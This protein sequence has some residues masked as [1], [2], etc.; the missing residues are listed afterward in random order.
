MS[1]LPL[2]APGQRFEQPEAVRKI[3]CLVPGDTANSGILYVQSESIP[4][5]VAFQRRL[6]ANDFRYEVKTVTSQTIANLYKAN[7][8]NEASS[9]QLTAKELFKY[10][11]DRKG[12]D[13]LI[14]TDK[15]KGTAFYMRILGDLY[16]MKDMTMNFEDGKQLQNSIYQSMSKEHSTTSY[17]DFSFMG[18]R[19]TDRN[20]LPE[21]LDSIRVGTGP[22]INDGQ[23]M[24]L[25]LQEKQVQGVT[26]A[27]LG[28]PELQ[29]KSLAF[30][31]SI[32][33]GIVVVTGPTGAGKT[34]TLKVL[35]DMIIE[36][37][38]GKKHV[39]TIEDPAEYPIEGA[40]QL[41]VVQGKTGDEDMFN[42]AVKGSLRLDPDTIL[43]GEVRD[44]ETANLAFR[45]AMTGHQVFTSLH[46]I[47]ALGA[48]SRLMDL[49]VPDYLVTDP[50]ILRGITA[51]RLVKTLCPHCKVKF[52]DQEKN[53]EGEKKRRLFSVIGAEDIDN[54]FVANP[55]GCDKCINGFNGRTLVVEVLVTDQ[56]LMSHVKNKDMMLAL[57]YLRGKKGYQTMIDVAIAKIKSGELDPFEVEHHVGPLDL[58]IL[59][60]DHHIDSDEL[61][62]H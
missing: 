40:N 51:Q 18:S 15:E 5:V 42:E 25:R 49:G 58:Q 1:N 29:R 44:S 11:A 41:K 4:P 36:Q 7:N 2:T 6:A 24:S 13:V 12:S 50:A 32:P 34:T 8:N 53:I 26:L 46:A 30:L 59:E 22:L 55:C 31:Q 23:L 3:M 37:S 14:I 45:A 39:L 10:G 27:E 60:K 48:L 19:I 47:N 62:R 33:N 57:D 35:M 16:E 38:Q 54:V 56:V 61:K 43:I 21:Q 17:E 28:V 52:E 9:T 20:I